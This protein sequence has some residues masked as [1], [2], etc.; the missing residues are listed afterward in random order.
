MARPQADG[1]VW[2]GVE[3][4]SEALGVLA[5]NWGESGSMK[6]GHPLALDSEHLQILAQ[7]WRWSSLVGGDQVQ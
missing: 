5:K 7:I 4:Q 1:S 2:P 6:R 3:E